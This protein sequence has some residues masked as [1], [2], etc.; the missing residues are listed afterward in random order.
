MGAMKILEDARANTHTRE[1]NA[2]N[3]KKASFSI[4]Q[5]TNVSLSDNAKTRVAKKTAMDSVNAIKTLIQDKQGANAT[6][7][8]LTTDSIN[9]ENVLTLY[10]SIQ[11]AIK[12]S[13]KYATTNTIVK[14]YPL[15]CLNTFMRHL[16][17]K[18]L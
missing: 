9:A 4:R 5:Q 12:G 3:A 11:I 1:N 10:L 6:L 14:I 17:R 8:S 13:G 7:A 15:K 18:S 2:I 16:K